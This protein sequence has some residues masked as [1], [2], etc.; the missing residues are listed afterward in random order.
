[1]TRSTGQRCHHFKNSTPKDPAITPYAEWP[2]PNCSFHHSFYRWLKSGGYTGSALSTY[3]VAARLALGYLNKLHWTID[4]EADLERVRRYMEQHYASSSTCREYNKGLR[5]LAE[6]LYLRQ[7]KAARPKIIHWEH[8]LNGL[9]DWLCEQVREY[10]ARRQKS[11]RIED[12]YRCSLQTLSPLCGILRWMAQSIPLKRIE[13][14]TPQL[15]FE[16]LDARMAAGRSVTTINNHLSC[17]KAFLLFL[18]EQDVSICQRMLLVD[19]LKE[20]PRIP[21][22]AS[23]SHLR[24]LLLEIEREAQAGHANQ[25]RMGVLDRAWV[26]LML[27]SGLHTCE[28]RHLELQDIEWDSRRIRIEQS[29]GLKDCLVY[30]NSATIQALRGWLEVRG[31]PEAFADRMFLYHHQLLSPRYCGVRLRTYGKRLESRSHRTSSGIPAPR[32]C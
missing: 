30:M 20:G 31:N 16:Y 23:I 9:P 21:K 15:W 12:R 26:Y 29:K 6:Y 11:W 5:K 18:H 3:S 19:P 7:N 10:L 22:D 2:I 27:Y 1:M 25:Q 4:P 14:I 28:V 8:Y 32:C 24:A 17:L 13:E